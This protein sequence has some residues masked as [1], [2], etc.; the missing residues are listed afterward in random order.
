MKKLLCSL[1]LLSIF[2]SSFAQKEKDLLK[3]DAAYSIGDYDKAQKG[4]EKFKKKA[5]KKLGAQNQYTSLLFI[6]EAH[7]NLAQGQL[8][9]FD[10]LMQNAE[11]SSKSKYGE[12][13]E[14][15]IR[16][17]TEI[18]DAWNMYGYYTRAAEQIKRANVLYNTTKSENLAL[19][20]YIDKVNTATL[21]GQG[22]YNEALALIEKHENYY[23]GR[24]VDRESS[25]D[26]K[27]KLNTVKLSTEEITQRYKDYADFLTLRGDAFAAKGHRDSTTWAYDF[28]AS[29]M[30]NNRK[31]LG[32]QSTAYIN[33]Q[34]NYI[35]YFVE[36]GARYA[37][38]PKD[39]KYE[40]ILNYLKVQHK[41]THYLAFPLYEGIMVQLLNVGNRARFANL[42]AEYEKN[43]KSSFKKTSLYT[44]NLRTV[45]FKTKLSKD[46]TRNIENEAASIL[47]QQ[48]VP[49]NHAKTIEILEFLYDLAVRDKRYLNAEGY[50][51]DLLTI[52]KEVF[53]ESSPEYHLSKVKLANF[54]LD[55]SNKIE[56][57][58]EIYNESYYGVVNKQ[59]HP[60]HKDNLNNLNHLVVYYENIDNY[61]LTQEVLKQLGEIASLKYDNKD[62]EYA[63]ALEKIA[64]FRINLGEY[65]QAR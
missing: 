20:V 49:R 51:N 56:L 14:N 46:R 63:I 50:L 8:I 60:F 12:N 22:F 52:K 64:S 5:N 33:N 44:T 38:L 31:Y 13:S 45:E 62:P 42:K 34:L 35:N 28:A 15:Y 65:E 2:V 47:I 53:G 39:L 6:K 23:V 61:D 24:A 3:I 16:T 29:F 41:T 55:Y 36:N 11:M 43:I 32:E 48:A 10:E 7:I 1:L 58:G 26:D 4:L 18:A 25:I 57:A 40:T 59:V 27:G 54:Y 17:I 21:I 30:T 9:G 37:D 19:R